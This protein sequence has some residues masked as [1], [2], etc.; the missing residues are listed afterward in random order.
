MTEPCGRPP[1]DDRV[2]SGVHHVIVNVKDLTRSRAFYGRL[3]PALGYPGCTDAG[4]A[5]ARH[6]STLQR[7]SNTVSAKSSSDA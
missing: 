3:L 1:T 2:A 6:A 5:V 7:G 4:S